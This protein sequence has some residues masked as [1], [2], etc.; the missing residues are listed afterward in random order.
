[1]DE[2]GTDEPGRESYPDDMM[3][4]LKRGIFQTMWKTTI[5]GSI[6]RYLI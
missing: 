4:D 3:M 6:L 2:K 5:G 1:M